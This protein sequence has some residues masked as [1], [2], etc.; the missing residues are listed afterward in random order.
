[1]VPWQIIELSLSLNLKQPPTFRRKSKVCTLRSG[2]EATIL[3]SER[4]FVQSFSSIT[5]SYTGRIVVGGH[6]SCDMEI[7]TGM[8]AVRRGSNWLLACT[9]N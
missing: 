6:W 7:W 8:V 4:P 1:M 5:G 2:S 3:I 9:V